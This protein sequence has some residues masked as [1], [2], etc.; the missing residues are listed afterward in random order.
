MKQIE[1]DMPRN[2]ISEAVDAAEQ[3]LM[4]QRNAAYRLLLLN[5]RDN[6]TDADMREVDTLYRNFHEDLQILKARIDRIL[7]NKE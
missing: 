4:R 7:G 3:F 1:L 5:S 6:W 2:D